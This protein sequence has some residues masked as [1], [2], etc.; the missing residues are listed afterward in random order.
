[1]VLRGQEEEF[2]A[3]IRR[4]AQSYA[5]KMT[6]QKEG[7]RGG[8]AAEQVGESDFINSTILMNLM[9]SLVFSA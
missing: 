9:I 6:N 8:K 7:S 2:H 1:M 4:V 5:E 3:E